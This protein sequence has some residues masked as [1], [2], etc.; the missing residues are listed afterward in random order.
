MGSCF[1]YWKVLSS[2]SS[3][4]VDRGFNFGAYRPILENNFIWLPFTPPPP[5]GCPLGPLEY[6][7]PGDSHRL[8]VDGLSSWRDAEVLI[9]GGVGG[10]F[11]WSAAAGVG[12]TVTTCPP[13]AQC[14]LGWAR[15]AMKRCDCGRGRAM[16]VMN[17]NW[18]QGLVFIGQSA[19]V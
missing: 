7:L 16:V 5:S 15:I 6:I 4:E 19:L 3:I 2:Y 1:C 11:R 18:V 10:E 12:K 17:K 14:R 8:A 13:C 9:F